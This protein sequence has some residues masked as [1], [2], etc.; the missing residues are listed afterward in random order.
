MRYIKSWSEIE[1]V[2]AG[3]SVRKRALPGAGASLVQVTIASGVSAPRHDH[4]HEQFV[5]VL[6]GSGT[7]TT[8]EGER[9]FG[10]GDIFHFPPGTWHAATFETETVLVETNLA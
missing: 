8:E 4:P 2:A 6:S 7:L 1:E 3:P 5:Q 10:P 9:E